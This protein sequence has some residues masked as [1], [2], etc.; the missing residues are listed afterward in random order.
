MKL[1]DAENRVRIA[2]HSG[3]HP[4]LYHEEVLR[5]LEGATRGLK[6]DAFNNAFRAELEAVRTE[7]ASPGSTLNKLVVK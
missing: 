1:E 4:R 6:G 2:G 3:P 5:R 7:V